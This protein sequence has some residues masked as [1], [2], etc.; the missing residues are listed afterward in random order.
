MSHTPGPWTIRYHPDRGIEGFPIGPKT[1]TIRGNTE[2]DDWVADVGRTTGQA[3]AL[4]NA[5]LIASAPE[6][7]EALENLVEA[8][9]QEPPMLTTEEWDLARAAIRKAQGG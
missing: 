2:A 3:V 5:T 6:L 1:I 7:L 8:H 4:A 9:D